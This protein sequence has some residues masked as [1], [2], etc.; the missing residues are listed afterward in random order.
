MNERLRLSNNLA[1]REG[2]RVDK[3]RVRNYT[4][5]FTIT[6]SPFCYREVEK[7]KK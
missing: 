6:S 1:L 3:E 2:V 5:R 4:V 7:T